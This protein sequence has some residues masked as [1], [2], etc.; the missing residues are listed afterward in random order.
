MRIPRDRASTSCAVKKQEKQL[1]AKLQLQQGED[2]D[3]KDQEEEADDDDM[4]WGAKK[5]AYYD[6]DEQVMRQ[7]PSHIWLSMKL[8]VP[9]GLLQWHSSLGL[10][11]QC[12]L[13]LSHSTTAM[14]LSRLTI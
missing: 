5:R 14:Q 3:L 1:R 8:T 7:L 11:Q 4:L 9:T 10:E 2:D 12:F 13:L 6:A